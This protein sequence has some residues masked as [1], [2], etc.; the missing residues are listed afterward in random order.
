MPPKVAILHHGYIPH[1]RVSFYEKLARAGQADYTVF[2]GAPPSW[3]GVP[4]AEGPF[5]FPNRWVE[6][7]EFRVGP[8]T[9]V[10]QPVLKEIFTGGYDAVVLSAEAKFIAN[11]ALAMFGPL[12]GL[13]VL[14]WGFGYHPQRGFRDSDA[15]RRRLV[16]GVNALKNRLTRRADGYLA[17]TR[18]GV[19]KLAAIGYPRDRAFV[20]HNTIDVSEQI[21]LCDEVAGE[22]PA[23]IRRSLGLRP[24]STVFTYIGR[25]VQFKRVDLLIEAVRKANAGRDKQIEALIVGGGPLEAEL[26][27]M[28]ADM[29][30]IHFLGTLPPDSRVARCLRVSA[31]VAIA[32]AL[33]L[34]INHAFAHGRA[35][36]TRDNEAHGAE[37]EYLAQDRNGLIVPGDIDQFAATLARFADDP[38][39]QARL[40]RGALQAREELRIENMVRRFDDAVCATV[41]RRR[42]PQ[43]LLR[44]RPVSLRS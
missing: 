2:H 14:Y 23:E 13:S 22:D 42:R 17:Y 10:Y 26:K 37:I 34:L 4:A 15:P 11:A 31:A 18:T 33:G 40:S 5:G 20:M 7:R 28:A 43:H 8:A 35:V 3:I 21:A 24:D 16:G 19:E 12:R 38:E 1:Y 32:G 44:D 29:P 41:A 27:A 25:L 6:N 30:E 39:W 9:A 36:I